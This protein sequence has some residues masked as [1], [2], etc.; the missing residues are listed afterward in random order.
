MFRRYE[1]AYL[2]LWPPVPLV[3]DLVPHWLWM[4]TGP[5][6]QGYVPADLF[7]QVVIP[8]PLVDQLE[9]QAEPAR[10]RHVI[11]TRVLDVLAD[12]GL[13]APKPGDDETEGRDDVRDA[14]VPRRGW[15]SAAPGNP[16]QAA[17]AAARPQ[18]GAEPR[19]HDCHTQSRGRGP[20]RPG[21]RRA[22]MGH[23]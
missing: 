5:C 8:R 15:D 14:T 11:Q 10:L 22:D 7:V 21:R 13:L 18:A 19:P 6:G 20:E 3:Q 23:R 1:L 9:K 12:F 16:G 4:L 2:D 17:A